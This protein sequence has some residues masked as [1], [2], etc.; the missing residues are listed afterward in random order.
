MSEFRVPRIEDKKI[1]DSIL[2]KSKF[3]GSLYSF[4]AIYTWAQRYQTKIFTSDEML[5][6]SGHTSEV[7]S[8]FLYPVGVYNIRNAVEIIRNESYKTGSEFKIVA[9]RCQVDELYNAFGD[10][11]KIENARNEWDYVYNTEDLA[12]LKGNRYHGKRNHI[13][14][15]RKKYKD[16]NFSFRQITDGDIEACMDIE[17]MWASER[18]DDSDV[19]SVRRALFEMNDLGLSGGVLEIDGKPIAFT[20]GEPLIKDTFVIHVEKALSGYDGAYQMINQMFAETLVGKYKF[21]NREED[22]GIEGLRASKLSYF[23]CRMIEK[24]IITERK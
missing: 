23:P 5:L 18:N 8:Y 14:K 12:L 13:S 11:F 3:E 19:E 21:I 20:I 1:I 16:S 2:S 7:G 10:E 6:I 4:A 17:R 15:L 9:E 24:C 22:M